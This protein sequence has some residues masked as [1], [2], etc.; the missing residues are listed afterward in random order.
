MRTKR[1]VRIALTW[2][3]LWLLFAA[4]MV[5]A[6]GIIDPDSIDEGEIQG[7]IIIFGP[8]GVLTGL[9][10]A[11]LLSIAGRGTGV[12]D[13]SLFRALAWGVLGSAL[14]QIGYLGHGDAGLA[15]NIGMALAFSTF[16]GIISV[17]WYFL[18]LRW[19]RV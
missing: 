12:F 19:V 18:A 4:L 9:A 17:I 7:A 8:M 10:F 5:I 2:S 16:G 1:I 3:F 11:F 15:A 14:V 6:L 13:L